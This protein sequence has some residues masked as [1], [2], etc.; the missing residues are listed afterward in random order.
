MFTTCYDTKIFTDI[1]LVEPGDPYEVSRTPRE[2]WFTLPWQPLKK[3]KTVV[4]MV[5][6][7]KVYMLDDKMFMH[8]ETLAALNSA[9]ELSN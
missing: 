3:T 8:P 1:N 9:L 2:R 4:P 6:S 7:K 5:P